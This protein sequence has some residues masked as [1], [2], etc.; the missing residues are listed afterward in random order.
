MNT[1]SVV[2]DKMLVLEVFWLSIRRTNEPL[3]FFRVISWLQL[4]VVPPVANQTVNNDHAT[5]EDVTAGYLLPRNGIMGKKRK[6]KKKK[7]RKEKVP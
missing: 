5:Q 3:A 2:R 1:E 4:I 6:E 7:K